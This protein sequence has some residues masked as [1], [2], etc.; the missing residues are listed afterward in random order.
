MQLRKKIPVAKYQYMKT[1]DTEFS[2]IE[3]PVKHGKPYPYLS[4]NKGLGAS[5]GENSA[6][7]V[8]Q[9]AALHR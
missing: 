1:A 8:L 5:I 6:V 9:L 7:D 4:K 2:P 3:A